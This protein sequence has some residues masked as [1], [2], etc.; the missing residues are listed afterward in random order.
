MKTTH[1]EVHERVWTM[2]CAPQDT[3]VV[4]ITAA[5]CSFDKANE[6][7]YESVENQFYFKRFKCNFTDE[8]IFKVATQDLVHYIDNVDH[9][10]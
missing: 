2:V 5:V 9:C 4:I 10:Q 3:C 7:L 1:E 6:S 8:D